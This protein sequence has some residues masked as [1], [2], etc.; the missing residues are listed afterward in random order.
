MVL[1][2]AE[3]T[4]SGAALQVLDIRD[5]KRLS[6]DHATFADYRGVFHAEQTTQWQVP[7]RSRG[8]GATRFAPQSNPG[9]WSR[10]KKS[11]RTGID[12]LDW[13]C[14]KFRGNH[15]FH[16]VPSYSMLFRVVL[17]DVKC[18]SNRFQHPSRTPCG[19]VSHLDQALE[20]EFELL[21]DVLVN[22]SDVRMPVLERFKGT[23]PGIVTHAVV[24]RWLVNGWWWLVTLEKAAL[25]R[26]FAAP[27]LLWTKSSA[28]Q[29]G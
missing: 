25:F 1:V 7:S 26:C 17:W 2:L 18:C 3:L 6:F 10:Q 4:I 16:P 21:I 28:Y 27:W 11:H 22:N 8:A 9:L 29:L 15:L 24:R 20:G 12:R 23:M 5:Q 13:L 14:W 19:P